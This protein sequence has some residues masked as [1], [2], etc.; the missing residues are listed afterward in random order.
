MRTC[1][2]FFQNVVPTNKK[3]SVCHAAQFEQDHLRPLKQF[4]HFNRACSYSGV[5]E[6]DLNLKVKEQ[7]NYH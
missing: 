6:K 5:N 4:I 1:R 7:E 3:A 2:G